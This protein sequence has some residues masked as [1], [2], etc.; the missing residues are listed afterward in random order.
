MNYE[1]NRDVAQV[2]IYCGEWDFSITTLLLLE[3][4]SNFG[5]MLANGEGCS[6]YSQDCTL[7]E[8][9]S[10]DNDA[11]WTPVPDDPV[12]IRRGVTPNSERTDGDDREYEDKVN[13]MRRD[14]G[15][16]GCREDDVLGVTY[17]TPSADP[18]AP[19]NFRQT[20]TVCLQ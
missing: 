13:F 17:D 5:E 9:I 7:T 2:R 18:A 11:R 6:P 20:I 15:N 12:A 4:E 16:L 1:T 3:K 10:T 14:T 19:T 8:N